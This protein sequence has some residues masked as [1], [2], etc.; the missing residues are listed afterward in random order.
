MNR[1]TVLILFLLLL[2]AGAAAFLLFCSQKGF[3]GSRFADPDFYRLDIARMTGTDLHTMK[4]DTGDV[5]QI[6]F[7][8]QKGRL[9]MEIIAPDGTVLYAG[10]G[11]EAGEFTVNI[12]ESGMYSIHVEA[13]H[14][15][16]TILVQRRKEARS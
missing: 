8:V 1:R 16:G 2:A 15:K 7:N 10:N 13:N 4:L 6:Q 14:A 5:L 3:A 11:K 9:Y 12:S